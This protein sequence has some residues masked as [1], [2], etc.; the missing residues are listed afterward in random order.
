M[1]MGPRVARVVTGDISVA[2]GRLRNSAK[3]LNLHFPILP[4]RQ[5]GCSFEAPNGEQRLVT[6]QHHIPQG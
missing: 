2:L 1:N 6:F 5:L 4:L 3:T